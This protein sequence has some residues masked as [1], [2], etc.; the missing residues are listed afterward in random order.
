MRGI[1]ETIVELLTTTGVAPEAIHLHE[2]ALPGFYRPTK[3]MQR[4]M[5]DDAETT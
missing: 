2:T 1:A 3:A 4:A 5:P